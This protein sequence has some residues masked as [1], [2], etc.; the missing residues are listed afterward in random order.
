MAWGKGQ[1]AAD[2]SGE[3][4]RQCPDSSAIAKMINVAAIGCGRVVEEHYLLPL[5]K[6]QRRGALRVAAL[7]DPSE[8]RRR[9]VQRHFPR[10]RDCPRAEE[11]FAAD[12]I[13]LSIIASPA[14]FHAEHA[15]TAFAHGSHVL[16]EKPLAASSREAG[17]MVSAARD[18]KGLLAVGQIRRFW[19]NIAEARNL[20]LNGE[21]GDQLQFVYRE[22]GEYRWPVTTEAAFTRAGGGG[23]VL[24]D[25]GVHL[26]DSL[27]WF[28]GPPQV[29]RCWDDSF[30][31]GV[32]TNAI[33]ELEFE[34]ARGLLQVSWEHAL[35]NG[36]HIRGGKGELWLD[37]A[38]IC[39][40]RR[41]RSGEPWMEI[42]AS[43][44]WPAEATGPAPRRCTPPTGYESFELQ[45]V[46]VLRAIQYGE[47][48]AVTGQAAAVVIRA[49]EDAYGK[50]EPMDFPWLSTSERSA[51][52]ARHW[53][54][55]R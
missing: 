9:S 43:A 50:A 33:L 41:R 20:V 37:Q 53:R 3:R 39:F 21:L 38:D 52:G 49:L 5:R 14:A 12:K 27:S 30:K 11:A 8:A 45:L 22:G 25:K 7:V 36:L 42:K 13:D 48:V 44:T 16:C 47:P 4:R 29:R 1:G 6:L 55:A 23:G 18:A 24:I 15:A 51:M 2:L 46:N 31:G 40:Y 10:A 34:R 32:E 19:P 26:L 28:F 35:N 54:A 17:A